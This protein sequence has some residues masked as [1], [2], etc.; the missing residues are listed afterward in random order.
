MNKAFDIENFNIIQDSE[1]YYFFRALNRGDTSDIES[2]ITSENGK[3]MKVRTDK[4]RWDEDA[5]KPKAKY[6]DE[7]AIT[8]EQMYDHIKMHQ[9]KDTNCISL[10]SNANVSI[11]YGR[12][13]YKDKYVAVRVPKAKYGEKVYNAGQYMMAEVEKKIQ[14]KIE[15]LPEDGELLDK[16][17]RL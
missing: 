9:R 8:L 17:K 13:Y 1:N 14:E 2:G 10:S 11:S 15:K 4:K 12:A 6:N 16:I 3:V 5:E 7:D